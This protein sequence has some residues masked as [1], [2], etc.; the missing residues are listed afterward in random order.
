MKC[1][2]CGVGEGPKDQG[3]DQQAPRRR[4]LENQRAATITITIV[5]TT[6]SRVESSADDRVSVR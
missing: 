2:I 5:R 1:Q 6:I 4:L 3:P